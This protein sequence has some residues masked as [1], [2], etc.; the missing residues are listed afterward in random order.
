MEQ[1][2]RILRLGAAAIVFALGVRLVLGGIPEKIAGAL[3]NPA[4]ISF[5][6]YLET[7]R[8]IRYPTP[9]QPAQ[10]APP[11]AETQPPTLPPETQAQPVFGMEALE[12]PDIT[13]GCSY[14]P[15]LEE[16]L[17]QPLSWDL[18]DG[19][20]AVLIV[21]THATECFTPTDAESFSQYDPYRTLSQG[22]NMVCLGQLLAQLLE[23]EGIRVIHDKGYH[24]YP[25][26]NMSY[27]HARSAIQAHLQ[28]Y[29]TIR[30]VLDLHRDAAETTQGQLTTSATVGNQRSAQLMMVVGT[31]A[32]GNHHPYWQENLA[33]A[34]K[35]S[36]VLEQE[37][38]GICR[39]VNLR[40]ERFNMDL[41]RG[42]LLVEVGAAGNTLQEASVA[43]HA[44]AQGIVKLAKGTP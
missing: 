27:I 36:A 18:T 8:V 37:N 24:D 28:Q 26:Y 40:S 10:T 4:L 16:L 25:D 31:D 43:I 14:R 6:I 29:P 13:Y 19:E 9:S 41:T 3:Q 15:A 42:S 30:M 44:L 35:L 2:R 20:P 33:L 34:L 22:H 21:H 17:A 7:G 1:H 39:P 23:A 12:L 38:P 11:P 5:L 32:G